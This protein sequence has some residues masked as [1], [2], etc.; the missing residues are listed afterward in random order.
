MKQRY[1]AVVDD[2]PSEGS[3]LIP[4]RQLDALG[5]YESTSERAAA[6]CAVEAVKRGAAFGDMRV[7][8]EAYTSPCDDQHAL[9]R[10]DLRVTPKG[11]T[12]R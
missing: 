7:W 9:H 12:K 2:F 5:I 10:F 3:C 11:S 4:G 1:M 6:R 8:V